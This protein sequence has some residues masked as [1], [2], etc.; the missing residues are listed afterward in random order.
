MKSV[1]HGFATALNEE[2]GITLALLTFKHI[3]GIM[4]I[5]DEVWNQWDD[6]MSYLL[7][8]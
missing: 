1:L 2:R 4:S 5:N 3:P 7:R 6:I 8:I